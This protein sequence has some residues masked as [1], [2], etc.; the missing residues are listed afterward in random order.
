MTSTRTYTKTYSRIALLQTNIRAALAA[1]GWP[2]HLIRPLVDVGLADENRFICMFHVYGMD[3]DTDTWELHAWIAVDWDEH[4]RLMLSANTV[5]VDDRWIDG[6]N[7][8]LIEQADGFA[9]LIDELGLRPKFVWTYSPELV[10]D[11]AK[12]ASALHVMNITT[13]IPFN[14]KPAGAIEDSQTNRIAGLGEVSFGSE[15]A[16]RS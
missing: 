8:G 13:T 3:P 12:K 1:Y 14:A 6:L 15:S 9:K 4:G 2:Q 16:F 11:P 7:P 10:R 5:T